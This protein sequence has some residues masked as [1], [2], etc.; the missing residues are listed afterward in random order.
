MDLW[1]QSISEV[2]QIELI[3]MQMAGN[4]WTYER[5]I[6]STIT[7]SLIQLIN[8][9]TQMHFTGWFVIIRALLKAPLYHVDLIE[10]MNYDVQYAS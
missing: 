3:W 2:A 1:N 9:V 8:G 5:S 7:K 4:R 6:S 10:L